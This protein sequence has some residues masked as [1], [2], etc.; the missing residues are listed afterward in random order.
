MKTYKCT[1]GGKALIS[2]IGL[3]MIVIGLLPYIWP[4][5]KTN[6]FDIITLVAFSLIGFFSFQLAWLHKVIINEK[7]ITSLPYN[8][9]PNT[10][11]LRW[12]EI[13]G[14]K[15]PSLEGF[16]P[17]ASPL[18]LVPSKDSGKKSILVSLWGMP[19]EMTADILA[20]IRPGTKVTLN[21]YIE[22]ELKKLAKKKE[23][24]GLKV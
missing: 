24:R 20:H 17:E 1:P 13:V 10:G 18:E 15:T 16:F 22:H 5:R 11:T 14:I 12:D 8:F 19:I 7:E 9:L 2:A 6:Y 21:Y 23:R 3:M 4:L